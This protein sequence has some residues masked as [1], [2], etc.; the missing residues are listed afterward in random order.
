MCNCQNR[1]Q[2]CDPD[3]ISN[4]T[5]VCYKEVEIEAS[6]IHLQGHDMIQLM[7]VKQQ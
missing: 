3:L 2:K 7:P 6:S 4:C 1:K 5:E